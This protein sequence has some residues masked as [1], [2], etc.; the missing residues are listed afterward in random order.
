VVI[1][2]NNPKTLDK[3]IWIQI[4]LNL[5]WG[6]EALNMAFYWLR[7][8]F[9]AIRK[10]GETNCLRVKENCLWV[11]KKSHASWKKIREEKKRESTDTIWVLEGL[12]REKSRFAPK[13]RFWVWGQ[14]FKSKQSKIWAWKQGI[15]SNL[16][17]F[18]WREFT[19]ILPDHFLLK[20]PCSRFILS[21]S[22]KVRGNASVHFFISEDSFWFSEDLSEEFLRFL[23]KTVIGFLLG[24]LGT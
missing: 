21:C 8:C 11:G 18:D 13:Q 12:K 14:S 4:I 16:K 5:R 17:Q 2:Y 23:Y 1:Y 9:T 24:C 19:P 10:R 15:L 3:R 6:L 20:A 7:S 22:T